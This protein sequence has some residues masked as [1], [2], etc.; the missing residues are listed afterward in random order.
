VAPSQVVPVVTIL[1]CM[2]EIPGS[3][4][5]LDASLTGVPCAFPQHPDEYIGV[6][7]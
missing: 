3:N 7:S 4:L 2:W 1:T 5:D 6:I